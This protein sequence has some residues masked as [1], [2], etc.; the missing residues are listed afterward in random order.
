MAKEEQN[1]EKLKNDYEILKN[2]H[3]LPDFKRLNEDFHIEKIAEVET[4]MLVREVRKFI[5]DKM[6]NYMRFLENLLNPVNVP[7]YIY[8]LVKLLDTEEKKTISEIYKKLIKK[9]IEFIELDLRFD[10]KKEAEFINNSYALWQEIKKDLLQI[11]DKINKKTSHK[12]EVNNKE[13]FG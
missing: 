6:L 8:S 1:L 4:E 3:N 9:E 2:N 13:Y 7:M 11:M 12:F 5:G 10:E